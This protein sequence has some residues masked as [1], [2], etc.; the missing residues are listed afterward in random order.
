MEGR[1]GPRGSDFRRDV[2]RA[3]DF[4]Q[5]SV[6]ANCQVRD[7]PQHCCVGHHEPPSGSRHR[8]QSASLLDNRV[9]KRPRRAR[10]GRQRAAVRKACASRFASASRNSF[11]CRDRVIPNTPVPHGRRR[12]R[13]NSRASYSLCARHRSSMFSTVAAP[14]AAYGS[15]WW[16][17]RNAVSGQRPVAADE[18][19]TDLRPAATRPGAPPP[20]HG[21]HSRASCARPR[22]L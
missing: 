13:K 15:T 8:A 10:R 12:P 1:P 6:A 5:G 3:V 19:R 14:P 20:G 2:S 7:C 21:A 18:P 11:R 4:D 16:N 17:S 22:G 9:R